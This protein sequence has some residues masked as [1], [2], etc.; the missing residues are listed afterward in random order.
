M[1]GSGRLVV[2]G[3]HDPCGA[4]LSYLLGGALMVVANLWDV[5]DKDIDRL[6]IECMRTA[7]TPY[8]PDGDACAL[9]T[10]LAAARNVCK[11]QYA[12]GSAPVMYGIPVPISFS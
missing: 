11:L 7:F 8:V 3:V 12:V 2:H 9:P 4:A 1:L 6:S 10:A 5:T